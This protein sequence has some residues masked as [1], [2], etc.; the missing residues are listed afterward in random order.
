MKILLLAIHYP[1]ASGRYIQRALQSLGHEVKTVGPCTGNEIWGLKVSKHW[2]WTPDFSVTYDTRT[3]LPDLLWAMNWYPDLVITADSAWMLP[4]PTSCRHVVWGVDNHVRDYRLREW[5]ALFL[6]HSG[7]ARM[8]ESNAHWLPCAYD[9]Q[10]H[11]DLGLERDL[12]VVMIGV[13]YPERVTLLR[14]MEAAGLKTFAATGL[15]WEDY[16]TAYNRAKIALVKSFSGDVAQRVFENMAQ[17]CC[18]LTDFC[19][20][21]PKL[22][23]REWIDYVPYDDV[24]DAV[25]QAKSLLATGSWKRIAAQGATQVMSHTWRNRATQLLTTLFGVQGGQVSPSTAPFVFSDLGTFV[26]APKGKVSL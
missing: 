20:D 8:D 15:L 18:V 21:L 6:A 13:P 1:V 24:D 4:G 2:Q 10:A 9:P 16:N 12:D 14:A 25:A 17:G 26:P 11:T 3:T 5:D 23:F 19:Q 7:G 22:G